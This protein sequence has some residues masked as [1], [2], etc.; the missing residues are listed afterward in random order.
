MVISNFKLIIDIENS[1]MKPNISHNSNP[2]S[3]L[4]PKMLT[5]SCS[6]TCF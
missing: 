1:N 4:T 3:L 6:S 5:N 2:T